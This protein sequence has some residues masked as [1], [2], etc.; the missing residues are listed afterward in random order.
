MTDHRQASPLR[1][2]RPSGMR[3]PSIPTVPTPLVGRQAEIARVLAAIDE[4]TRLV[5][6]TGLGGI[7]KTR[8]AIGIAQQAWHHTGHAVVFT[9]LRGVTAAAHVPAAVAV[10][11]GWSVPDDADDAEAAVARELATGPT[12]LVLDN[13]EQVGG[14]PDLVVRLMS[15][16]PDLTIVVTSRRALGLPGELVIAI[17]PLVA[18]AGDQPDEVSASDAAKL[19]VQAAQLHDPGFTV[20][21]DNSRDVADLCRRLD[22]IPLAIEL[23]APRLRLLSPGQVVELLAR[24]FDLLRADSGEQHLWATIDWSYRELRADDRRRF[25]TLGVFPES[26]DLDAA[27]A[28]IGDDTIEVLDTLQRLDRQQFVRVVERSPGTTRFA[29]LETLRAFSL[30]ELDAHDETAVARDRHADWCHRLV[31]DP[32]AAPQ[33]DSARFA[34][35]DR[36]RHDVWSAL[37]RLHESGDTTRAIEIPV[38]LWPYWYARGR[39]REGLSALLVAL[40]RGDAPSPVAARGWIAAGELA[41][42]TLELERAAEFFTRGIELHAEL[43]DEAALAD[44]QNSLAFVLREQGDLDR[45][46]HLH[47]ESAAVFRRLGSV[48]REASCLN[49]V[50][51]IA[52]TR[53]EAA[54]AAAIW[55]HVLDLVE[56]CG[57][58]H[59]QAAIASNIGVARFALGDHEAALAAHGRSLTLA[60]ELDDAVRIVAALVNRA[61]VAIAAGLEDV[62]DEDLDRADELARSFAMP[63]R[64][65]NA[66]HHRGMLADRRGQI[67]RAVRFHLDGLALVLELGHLL[68]AV[69]FVERLGVLAAELGEDDVARDCFAVAGSFRGASGTRT[70]DDVT[71]ALEAVAR[72]DADA[73]ARP[74]PEHGIE[75]FADLLPELERVA[76]THAHAM[77]STG[78]ASVDAALTGLGLSPREVEVTHL[79]VANKTDAEIADELYIGIRTVG[80]HVSSILRK[81]GV[82]S[83]R[84]VATELHEAGIELRH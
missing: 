14:L 84:E 70:P 68:E 48:R 57:D 71:S 30:A 45:A 62:A 41:Y 73:G 78:P 26:F 16:A 66:T 80:S 72:R 4:P 82:T 55:E 38:A 76:L 53:G 63:M 11:A 1:L 33:N 49:G 67:G 19:L 35:F 22:G 17:E 8:V 28:V 50:A 74:P 64:R 39:G 24:R 60:T 69:V 43:G 65:A 12:V 7:G 42:E 27:A 51:A 83:R 31:C 40:D 61:E 36:V 52:A 21:R 54:Q 58:R 23:A 47:R 18:P 32:S 81:L 79:L 34:S 29:L 3:P 15:A 37:E 6:I 2:V 56:Q 59:A 25:R 44:G 10:A 20:T 75:V 9:G 13:V 77:R 5:S 46:E